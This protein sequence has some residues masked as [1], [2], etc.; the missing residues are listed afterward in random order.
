MRIM[1]KKVVAGGVVVL[2]AAAALYLVGGWRL[3]LDGSGWRPR[4]DHAPDFDALEAE[5]ARQPRTGPASTAAR[6]DELA[7]AVVD[8]PASPAAP[9]ARAV[10]DAAASGTPSSEAA[11]GA[12][13]PSW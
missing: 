8:A 6:A 13:R 7:P 4:L 12:T 1:G 9:A 10:S 3:A 5:R 2:A 11:P